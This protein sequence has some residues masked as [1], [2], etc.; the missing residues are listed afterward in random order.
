MTIA[1]GSTQQYPSVF[2]GAAGSAA[3][4][5]SSERILLQQAGM[6]TCSGSL[7]QQTNGSYVIIPVCS[8]FTTNTNG[9]TA[10]NPTPS[11]NQNTNP[12]LPQFDTYYRFK[13]QLC[14]APVRDANQKNFVNVCD[15][16]VMTP[17][18]TV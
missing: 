9:P 7:T 3:E 5:Y 2:G 4:V 12:Y 8:T 17:N 6:Q 10:Q 11:I 16:C 15:T 14:T 1:T 18:N 13:N